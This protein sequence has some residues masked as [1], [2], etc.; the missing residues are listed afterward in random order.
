[1]VARKEGGTTVEVGRFDLDGMRSTSL[2]PGETESP[3]DWF[4]PMDGSAMRSSANN[5]RKATDLLMHY[6]LGIQTTYSALANGQIKL[7][8]VLARLLTLPKASKVYPPCLRPR[9]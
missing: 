1:M 4:T 2:A 8:C 6:V 7:E 9:L 3:F 5:L